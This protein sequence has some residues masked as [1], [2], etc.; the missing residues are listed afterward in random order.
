VARSGCLVNVI[1]DGS[2]AEASL[3]WVILEAWMPDWN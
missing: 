1:P 3:Y 2:F